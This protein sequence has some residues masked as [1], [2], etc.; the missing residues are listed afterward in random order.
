MM[1]DV[2]PITLAAWR[3]QLTSVLLGIGAA[4]QLCGMPPED[5]QRTAQSAGLL[6]ASGVCLALHFGT[7]VYSVQATS[8]THSLLFVSATPLFL[9]GG[10]WLLGRPISAGELGGT[11][12]GLAGGVLLATAAARADAQVTLRGDMAALAA[13]LCFVGYLLIGQRLRAWMPA[14]VYAFFVTGLAALLLTLSALLF[15]GARL[16]AAGRH[17]L[18]GW[19]ADLHY[20]PYVVYLGVVPGIVGHTGFNT[21]LRH[22]NPLIISLACN[23]EPLL[24]SLLGWAV[25]VVTAPGPWTYVGGALVLASTATVS[26][27]SHRREK[28]QASKAAASRAI[29]RILSSS[30]NAEAAEAGGGGG[31]DDLRRMFDSAAAEAWREDSWGP[32]WAQAKG[33]EAGA[34]HG[35]AGWPAGPQ[36]PSGGK[37]PDHV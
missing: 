23:L 29:Q 9:A 18:L 12:V 21:L 6:A 17:G 27:A 4:V 25:G 37:P 2:P 11:A 3:L 28:K 20:L 34:S 22:L 7:W 31:G 33:G 1:G 35:S 32:A 5:R 26:I 14:F 16:L 13:S 36:Q 30:S 24:G 19:T 10:T 8:L 15:E